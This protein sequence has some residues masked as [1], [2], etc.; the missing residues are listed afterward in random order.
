MD[1]KDDD[2]YWEE[3]RHVDANIGFCGL[4]IREYKRNR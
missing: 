4:D 2:E 3:L 1:E